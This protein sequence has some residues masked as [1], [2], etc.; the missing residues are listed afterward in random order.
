LYGDRRGGNVRFLAIGRDG[1]WVVLGGG[2]LGGEVLFSGEVWE[3]RL[4][5]RVVQGFAD[6]R[7]GLAWRDFL[8]LEVCLDLSLP[9]SVR[10]QNLGT[11]LHELQ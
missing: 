2:V 1:L 11:D 6:A 4:R 9:S 7:M 10:E 3:V 5:L 8:L